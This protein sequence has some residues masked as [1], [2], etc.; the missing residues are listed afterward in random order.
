MSNGMVRRDPGT[1]LEKAT[2]KDW[3]VGRRV[4]LSR[5]RGML[6]YW[7]TCSGKLVWRAEHVVD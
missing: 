2:V 7:S 6:W 4:D 1:L 5:F 3:I